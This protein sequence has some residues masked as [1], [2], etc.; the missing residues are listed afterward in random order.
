MNKQ[1]LRILETLVMSSEEARMSQSSILV[2]DGGNRR[3][4][5][6]ERPSS[7]LGEWNKGLTMESLCRK[8]RGDIVVQGEKSMMGCHDPEAFLTRN[9]RL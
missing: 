4:A 3:P 5:E 9:R 1:V 2:E 6:P 7:R 8:R